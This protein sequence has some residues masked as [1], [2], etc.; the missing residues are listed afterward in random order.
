M[1]PEERGQ[2]AEIPGGEFSGPVRLRQNLKQYQGVNCTPC[3]ILEQ[4]QRQHAD[5]VI[6]AAVAVSG[7]PPDNGRPCES[8]PVE[9]QKND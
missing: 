7:T 8:P 4:V 5:F 3:A 9:R 2:G 1:L 6:L